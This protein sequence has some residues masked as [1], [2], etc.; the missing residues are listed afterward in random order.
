MNDLNGSSMSLVS[1]ISSAENR[2]S[3][4]NVMVT[5]KRKAYNKVYQGGNVFMRIFH[6][7]D[8]HIGLRLLHQD[9]R[10]DQEHMF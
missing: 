6:L 7:S 1:Y 5:D 2:N 4:C 9:L 8:L 3:V 10:E